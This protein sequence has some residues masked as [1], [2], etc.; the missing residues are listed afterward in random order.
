M[1]Q[2]IPRRSLASLV[3]GPRTTIPAVTAR[4]LGS[5][6]IHTVVK[7][8]ILVEADPKIAHN[9]CSSGMDLYLIASLTLLHVSYS[10]SCGND[11]LLVVFDKLFTS[12]AQTV[13]TAESFMG[14]SLLRDSFRW[15]SG[16]CHSGGWN[17]ASYQN[18]AYCLAV[19]TW[20]A[21]DHVSSPPTLSPFSAVSRVRGKREPFSFASS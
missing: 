6:C 17:R 5:G 12:C 3:T 7:S 1:E 19:A 2:T 8:A 14:N 13:R 21:K 18:F 15:E 4:M 10:G 11:I 9:G 16:G 20:G